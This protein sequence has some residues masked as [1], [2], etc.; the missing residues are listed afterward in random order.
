MANLLCDVL[1]QHI[2]A[3]C[4]IEF[5]W[6]KDRTLIG[7]TS[8]VIKFDRIPLFTV[9]FGPSEG[10]SGTSGLVAT[11]AKKSAVACSALA[12]GS[13]VCVNGFEFSRTNLERQLLEFAISTAF[14]KNR[15][16]NL[17]LELS[18]LEMGDYH[19]VTN[20]CRDFVAKAMD[21]ISNNKKRY[22]DKS[23][24][25]DLYRAQNAQ[26]LHRKELQQVKMEDAAKAAGAGVLAGAA[27]AAIGYGLFKA[28]SSND[29]ERQNQ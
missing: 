19:V 21:I 3:S 24:D 14:G 18:Q 12:I 1:L 22:A 20:N 7:H 28:F 23:D 29:K 5:H 17:L 10:Q 9:D 16:I 11:A 13:K 6:R 26:N 8:I 27:V 25:D 2:N 4:H 15:A